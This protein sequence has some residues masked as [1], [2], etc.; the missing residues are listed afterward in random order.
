MNDAVHI[1]LLA[2]GAIALIGVLAGYDGDG[3]HDG[4]GHF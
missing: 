3:G 2:I 1:I 4:G